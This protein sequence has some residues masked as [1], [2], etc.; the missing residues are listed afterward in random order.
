MKLYHKIRSELWNEFDY[1]ILQLE[2]YICH[3]IGHIAVDCDQFEYTKKGNLIKLYNQF[4]K[5]EG[6][7][8][9]KAPRFRRKPKS[10]LSS[11]KRL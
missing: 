3:A 5:V 4:Y 10:G 2:C 1:A 6:G 9:P 8:T 7:H 11:M